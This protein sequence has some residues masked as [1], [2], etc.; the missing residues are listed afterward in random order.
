M[1]F[2]LKDKV[3]FIAG[4]SQGIGKATAIEL[5]KE[6]AKVVI[7]ALDDPELPKAVEEIRSITGNEVIGIAADLTL[8]QDAKNFI[9]KGV[10]HFGTIDIL[11]NN[12]GGPPDKK[13]TEIDEDLWTLG[14]RL[15]LLS[16]ITMT[17]E[18]VPVMMEKRWGRI[19]N[20][21]SVSVK[22]PIPG[23]ILSNTIRIGVVGLAKTLSSELAP[24]NITV[25]NV[26][27]AYIATERVR[28]L[29]IDV[30]KKEGTTPE[31]IIRKWESQMVLGRMGEPDEVAALITFLASE[32]AG[33]ITG[34]SIQIDG[35]YYKGVM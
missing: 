2:G 10:E 16:T 3:A 28:K 24:Y 32:R 30:A 4:A 33:F 8:T 15:N 6:G 25:N 19:I 18:A 5:S 34:D 29:S 20:M 22:Q 21:T 14:F 23:L 12:S 26:C 27:P 9:R 11:V 1:D 17:Q 35:G 7:C 31:E 13:F